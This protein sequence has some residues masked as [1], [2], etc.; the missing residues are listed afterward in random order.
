MSTRIC[1]KDPSPVKEIPVMHS[2]HFT[3]IEWIIDL[4]NQQIGLISF[5]IKLLN[6]SQQA[7]STESALK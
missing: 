1:A 3:I 2:E 4:L 7:N 5:S 6:R